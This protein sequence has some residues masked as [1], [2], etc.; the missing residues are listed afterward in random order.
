MLFRSNSRRV[1]TVVLSCCPVVAVVVDPLGAP[2]PAA[3]SDLTVTLTAFTRLIAPGFILAAMVVVVR[4]PRTC[5]GGG[6]KETQSR[7]RPLGSPS[8]RDGTL[9]WPA[10][11]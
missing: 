9:L 11:S 6:E 8:P 10:C 4:V 2:S 5:K 7:L 1:I 3:S